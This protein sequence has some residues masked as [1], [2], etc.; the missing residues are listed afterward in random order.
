MET[1]TYVVERR[2]KAR[3]WLLEDEF[4]SLGEAMDHATREALIYTEH[5]HRILCRYTEEV[6]T[7][8]RLKDHLSKQYR[9]GAVP[10]G[11]APHEYVITNGVKTWTKGE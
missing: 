1:R 8:P 5:E 11:F 4:D 7:I 2:L 9:E 10:A 3:R 6:L